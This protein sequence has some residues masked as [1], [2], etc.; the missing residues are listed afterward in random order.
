MSDVIDAL[1]VS[2]P[3]ELG[4]LARITNAAA[5]EDAETRRLITL[6]R[7]DGRVEVRV[8]HPIYGEVRRARAPET[9]LRRLRGLI[10]AELAKCDGGDECEP[11]CGARC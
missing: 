3:I 5:V 2:E 11:W 7:I 9:K 4:S 8:A 6:H 1:A 10:A